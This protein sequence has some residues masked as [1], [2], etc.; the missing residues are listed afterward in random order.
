MNSDELDKFV[1]NNCKECIYDNINDIDKCEIYRTADN[2]FICKQANTRGSNL[3]G[4]NKNTN[5]TNKI[6]LLIDHLDLSN[7][8][9]NGIINFK[10]RGEIIYNKLFIDENYNT[11]I[12]Y[13][14]TAA[15]INTG[16]ASLIP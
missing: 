11:T 7:L 16:K 10:V 3:K 4:Y 12:P 13:A 6:N 1:E 2:K 14:S 5:L 9:N 8:K 15:G